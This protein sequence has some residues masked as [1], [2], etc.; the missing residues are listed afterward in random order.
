M[1]WLNHP[2]VHRIRDSALTRFVA[3][4]YKFHKRQYTHHSGKMNRRVCPVSGRV[5]AQRAR[6]VYEP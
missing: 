6:V 4:E 2:K 1:S 3:R 5:T